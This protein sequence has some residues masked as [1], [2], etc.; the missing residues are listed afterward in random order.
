MLG[1]DQALQPTPG[2]GVPSIQ[3]VKVQPDTP[4]DGGN[5]GRQGNVP[6]YLT[7]QGNRTVGWTKPLVDRG[8]DVV[9]APVVIEQTQPGT[10]A[11]LDKRE[12]LRQLRQSGK[13]GST[14][15]D[16]VGLRTTG[17]QD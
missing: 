4:R 7:G 5:H 1:P 17:P 15:G 16:L 10:G 11:H 2:R 8:P 9:I 6:V 3:W 14:A 12:W 13:N